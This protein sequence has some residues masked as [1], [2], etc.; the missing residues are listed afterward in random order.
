MNTKPTLFL[1]VA[2]QKSQ[3][4]FYTETSTGKSYMAFKSLFEKD[5]YD[6]NLHLILFTK[7]KC[8][9]PQVYNQAIEQFVHHDGIFVFMHDDVSLCDF[10]WVNRLDKALKDFDLVGVA[11]CTT[12][13]PQQPSW[14]FEFETVPAN[15]IYFNSPKKLVQL[16]QAVLSGMIAHQYTDF[17]VNIGFFGASNQ[18][19]KLLD[20]V[21]L[22]CRIATLRESGLRFDTRFNFHFYDLDLCRSAEQLGLK[23][24]TCDVS[25][26]HDSTGAFN[27]PIWR[28][29]LKKYFN[30]WGD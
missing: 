20:G 3:A 6:F 30:K 10:W 21:F 19:V 5:L 8:G 17:F 24:G 2:T 9:L 27:T 12:R 7:N 15:Q 18:E 14:L 16:N 26:I 23:M 1:V 25:L 28:S 29:E 4:D 11:G 22:A 13:Q